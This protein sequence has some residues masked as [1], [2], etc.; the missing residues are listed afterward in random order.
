MIEMAKTV[1]RVTPERENV[2]PRPLAEMFQ[3]PCR[4]EPRLRIE[5]LRSEKREGL[6]KFNFA[7]IIL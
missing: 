7:L 4:K 6:K 3:D 1:E 2:N 5:F